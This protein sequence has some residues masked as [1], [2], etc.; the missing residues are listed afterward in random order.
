MPRYF[1][2]G[3]FIFYLAYC[4]FFVW[5]WATWITSKPKVLQSWRAAALLSGM[6]FVAISVALSVFLYV[7][8]MYTGG[9]RRASHTAGRP[10]TA[11]LD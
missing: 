2:F 1:Q 11:A 9:Y 3:W 8:A 4:G 10:K 5:C 7:H 6:L